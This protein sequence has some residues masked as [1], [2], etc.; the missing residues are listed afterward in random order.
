M[1]LI[2]D[3][4]TNDQYRYSFTTLAKQIFGLDINSWYEKGFWQDRYI[5]YSFV[6][7]GQVIANVSV[8]LLD[9]LIEGKTYQAIQIGTV[10]THPDYRGK[11]LS[12]QLIQYVLE[13]YAGT[14]DYM[15]LFA[16]ESVLNFYPK[17]GFKRVE[18]H[19]FSTKKGNRSYQNKNLQKLDVQQKKDL[20]KVYDMV[21]NRVP[22]SN[23]FAT[24]QTDSLT[25]FH[26]LNGF[27]DHLYYI[28]EE[29]AIVMFEKRGTVLH[30]YDMICKKAF[31][32]EQ[33]LEKVTDDQTEKI[34]LYFTPEQSQLYEESIYK[35]NGALFVK[36]ENGLSFPS[37]RMHPITSEA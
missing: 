24:L 6:E 18:E 7:S 1:K 30:V 8:N 9:L 23:S 22:V 36:E 5:P 17:F 16:N 20:E 19:Q 10:M 14:Y 3:Y 32:L 11:G 28:L 34:C 4:K 2:K 27:Q 31:H 13:E 33:L 12:S 29:D 26:C 25:M 35:R 21:K 37:K 15:Y